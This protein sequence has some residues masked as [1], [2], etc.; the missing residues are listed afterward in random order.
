MQIQGNCSKTMHL[1]QKFMHTDEPVGESHESTQTPL[2]AY[3]D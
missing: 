2:L 3:S 1:L